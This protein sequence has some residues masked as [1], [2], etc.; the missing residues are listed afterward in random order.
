M[1]RFVLCCGEAIAREWVPGNTSPRTSTT[2]VSVSCGEE[3]R[4]CYLH[5]HSGTLTSTTRTPGE[6]L[7]LLCFFILYIH[8]FVTQIRVGLL[9]ALK[10]SKIHGKYM[11]GDAGQRSSRVPGWDG[12]ADTYFSNARRARQFVEGTKIQERYLCG[13]RLEAQLNGRAESAVEGCRPGCPTSMAWKHCYAFSG[14]TAPS[15]H[16]PTWNLTYRSSSKS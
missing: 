2:D 11:T 15:L 10:E 8:I 9:S 16:Y 1:L 6:L 5:S 7:T 14:H 13:P 4:V 12:E 3:K